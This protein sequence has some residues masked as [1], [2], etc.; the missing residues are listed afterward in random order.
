MVIG[1]LWNKNPNKDDI[2][3]HKEPLN[4][5]GDI[6]YLVIEFTIILLSIKMFEFSW[7]NK[8]VISV[9]SNSNIISLISWISSRSDFL[10]LSK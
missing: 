7:G 5:L 10:G 9:S 6:K 3:F 2:L 1:G 8:C 4:P